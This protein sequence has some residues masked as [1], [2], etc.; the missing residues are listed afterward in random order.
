MRFSSLLFVALMAGCATTQH[1]LT[2]AEVA[3][4]SAPLMCSG[5]AEC[6]RYWQRAQIWLVQ[7]SRWRMQV[8]TDT[9]LEAVGNDPYAIERSYR[10]MKVPMEGESYRLTIQSGCRNIFGCATTDIQD[11]LR[12]KRFVLAK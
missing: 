9:V 1:Q 11:A 4:A 3:E 7:T 5:D 2:E 8:A 12:F 6:K 10:I